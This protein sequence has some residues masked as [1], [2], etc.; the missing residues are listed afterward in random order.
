MTRRIE[1]YALIG[2]LETAALV[3]LDGSIDWLCVPRF[4]S[5]ACFA[6]LLGTPEHGRFL[7]APVSSPRSVSR[8]YRDDT[9]IVE[10]TFETESGV[11]TIVDAMPVRG[12]PGPELVRVVQGVSGAV[13]MRCE[14]VMRFDYGSV[15]P[16]VTRSER[17]VVAIGGPDRLVVET[18]IQLLGEGL[19]TVAEFDVHAGQAVPFA[20]GWSSSHLEAAWPQDPFEGIERTERFWTE[21]SSRARVD[22]PHG[23][24]VRRSLITLKA[25]THA[26]TGGIVAAP[27]TSLP[28]QL[29]GTRNWDYRYTWL[30]DS[31]F[32][33]YALLNAGYDAEAAA[34]CDWLARAVAGSPEQAQILYRVDGARRTTE[35][36]LDLPGFEGSK[37]V[38][39][40]NAAARQRQ[41]DV[42]GEVLDTMHQSRRLGFHVDDS[43][44]RIETALVDCACELWREPDFGIWEIREPARHHTFSKVMAWVAVDRGVQ[45]IER[46]GRDG[47]LER[48]KRVRDDIYADVCAHGV[49]PQR[50]C[51]VQHYGATHADASTLLLAQVGFVAPQDPRFV[52]TIR[53]VED[54]L[55][56][57]EGLVRRYDPART[58]DGLAGGEGLFL[59]CSFWLV[60]AYVLV[61][62]VHDARRLF[63]HLLTLPNDLGLLAE[64]YDPDARRMLGNFPQALSHIALVNSARNLAGAGPA[65]HR[66]RRA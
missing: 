41:H 18:P 55:V 43:I 42:Y 29:G 60:D 51:F 58:S 21:W 32:A 50:N 37:P 25:L 35:L 4:D 13:R 34:W 40:G 52:A 39:I 27:T 14:L 57:P 7:L 23:A 33:L 64:Q 9:L 53:A 17:G 5:G 31:T 63:D 56:S 22:G 44:W 45:A 19:R 47:P 8:R 11:V 62:R 12:A 30:R 65:H 24:I 61:G 46:F 16:W 6:A 54:E 28:E 15:V 26:P 20:L 66:R 10:T 36:E 3:G 59:A 49:D 1:D 48:W 38:R 2:D